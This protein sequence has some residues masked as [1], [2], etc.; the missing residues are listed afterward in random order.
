MN[1]LK[2]TRKSSLRRVAVVAFSPS[3]EIFK[4]KKK[5]S[6]SVL[7]KIGSLSWLER[8]T[9]SPSFGK[10][11]VFTK[12]GEGKLNRIFQEVGLENWFSTFKDFRAHKVGVKDLSSLL[13]HIL[14][15]IQEAVSTRKLS[16]NNPLSV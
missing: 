4:K 5:T 2:M 12:G 9:W 11:Q 16:K 1:H 8:N 13:V 15:N 3:M 10:V 7:E 6:C 14:L